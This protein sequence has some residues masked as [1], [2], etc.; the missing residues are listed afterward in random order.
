MRN[1]KTEKFK[2]IFRTQNS[3]RGKLSRTRNNKKKNQQFGTRAKWPL[4]FDDICVMG[5][6]IRIGATDLAEWPH[7]HTSARRR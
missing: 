6:T 4:G 7:E 5:N 1:L 2:N 3:L